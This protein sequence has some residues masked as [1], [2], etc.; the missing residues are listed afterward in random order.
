MKVVT[1]LIVNEE[2]S[3]KL[4]GLSDYAQLRDPQG[5]IL[6]YF[7]PSKAQSLCEGID[8]PATEEEL[9]QAEKEPGRSLAEILRDLERRA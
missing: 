6:G 3:S 5:H 2:L 8:C 1:Q 4:C 9:Q 7:M